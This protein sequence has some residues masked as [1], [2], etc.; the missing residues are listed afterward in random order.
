[1]YD[2]KIIGKLPIDYNL[3]YGII[4]TEE[5][6]FNIIQKAITSIS[7]EEKDRIF[8]KWIAVEQQKVT[9]YSLVWKVIFVA[10]FFIL[11][12]VY[13]NIKLYKAKQEIEKTNILLKKAQKEIEDKNIALEK[14]AI[15][16][17]LTDVYNRTKLDEI[18][19][20]EI[21][22][23]KR[24]E[25]SFG[26]CILDIDYFKSTNDSFGHLVGD[27][28]L[29]SFAKLLKESIRETDYVG[30]WG[31]EEFVIIVP[32]TN[33]ENLTAFAQKLRVKIENFDFEKVGKKT[34]SFGITVTTE[35]D[36]IETVIKRADDALYQAK[37]NGRNKV[38][39]L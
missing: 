3:S 25:C 36:T 28:I 23:C 21:N 13:W 18:L 8:R 34:A 31:G 29:I 22:R 1:M 30:R 10:T 2:L 38:C 35:N 26:F 11:L 19:L 7:K 24:F 32:K 17:K 27:K 12:I 33:K 16:D 15:T 20:D 9:D 39:F 14:L 5:E 37:K 6:L 4:N